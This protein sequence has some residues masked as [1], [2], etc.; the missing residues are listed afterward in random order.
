M[1]SR[2]HGRVEAVGS[3]GDEGAECDALDLKAHPIP[4]SIAALSQLLAS[5]REGRHHRASLFV[6]GEGEG[7]GAFFGGA[8]GEDRQGNQQDNAQS[9]HLILLVVEGELPSL[10]LHQA[11]C[12]HPGELSGHG[13]AFDAE[14]VGELL[15]VKWNG[16][17]STLLSLGFAVEVG[18]QLVPRRTLGKMIDLLQ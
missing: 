13:A 14:V 2:H 6:E 17:G 9:L 18:E 8:R 4:A 15:A 16:E 5:H 1:L 12:L 10:I 11:I 7:L 3:V